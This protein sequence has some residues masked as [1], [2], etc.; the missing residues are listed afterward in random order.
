M[1]EAVPKK[2]EINEKKSDFR[3]NKTMACQPIGL[4]CWPSVSIYIRRTKVS[5]YM[6]RIND[7][8][9]SVLFFPYTE[10]NLDLYPGNIINQ[11]PFNYKKKLK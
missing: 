5:V 11:S 6:S 10:Y 8:I 1:I 4:K 3:I 9:C 7:H 2:I